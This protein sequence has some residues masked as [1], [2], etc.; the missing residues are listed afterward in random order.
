MIEAVEHKIPRLFPTESRKE[1]VSPG[2]DHIVSKLTKAHPFFRLSSSVVRM[3]FDKGV[4]NT[5]TE[6]NEHIGS[7]DEKSERYLNAGGLDVENE[8]FQNTIEPEEAR[9]LTWLQVT[10]VLVGPY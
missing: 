10:V 9:S 2:F 5:S 6:Q 4:M 8:G 3:A 1:I 7:H